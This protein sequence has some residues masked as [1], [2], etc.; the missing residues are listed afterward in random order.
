[1]K[2]W[3]SDLQRSCLCTPLFAC[4]SWLLALA[5]DVLVLRRVGGQSV[6][7]RFR[8]CWAHMF[9]LQQ[10]VPQKAQRFFFLYQTTFVRFLSIRGFQTSERHFCCQTTI[11]EPVSHVSHLQLCFSSASWSV[12]GIETSFFFLLKNFQRS[13]RC[14]CVAS[15]TCNKHCVFSTNWNKLH[16]FIGKEKHGYQRTKGPHMRDVLRCVRCLGL[17]RFHFIP[18]LKA[19]IDLSPV[20]CVTAM[21]STLCA[22]PWVFIDVVS[23]L[24]P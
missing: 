14:S 1:M 4:C 18:F 9:C 7:S 15:N 8:G 11:P 16:F 10:L 12:G 3:H 24:D 17:M 20:H 22:D 13:N 23:S 2:Y 5:K 6:T 21:L 19:W